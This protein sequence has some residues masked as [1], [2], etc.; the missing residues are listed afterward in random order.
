MLEFPSALSHRQRE[1][2]L[3]QEGD[4]LR[5]NKRIM[6]TPVCDVAQTGCAASYFLYALKASAIKKQYAA[7]RT[8]PK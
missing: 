8:G 6:G 5:Q 4:P 2:R 3:K 1:T 7:A